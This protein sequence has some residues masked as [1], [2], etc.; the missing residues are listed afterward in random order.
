MNTEPRK[1][2]P[3]P[4][5]FPTSTP[6]PKTEERKERKEKPLSEEDERNLADSMP[7]EGPAGD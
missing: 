7:G 4:F 5:P 3:P 6:T 2:K 1:D